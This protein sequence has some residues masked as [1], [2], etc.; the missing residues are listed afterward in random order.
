MAICNAP[1]LPFSLQMS[2]LLRQVGVHGI[3][4]KFT[5]DRG[6]GF[7]AT[8]LPEVAPEQGVLTGSLTGSMFSSIAAPFYLSADI[9]SSVSLQS[10]GRDVVTC[11]PRNTISD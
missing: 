2:V 1:C 5:D 9:R 8:F 10:C 11:A 3:V 4:I 7:S 6:S